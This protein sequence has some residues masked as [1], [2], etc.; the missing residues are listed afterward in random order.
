MDLQPEKITSI[1]KAAME[2]EKQAFDMEQA[3]KEL[4]FTHDPK[5]S[6]FANEDI[7]N[8]KLNTY[9]ELF[10]RPKK[11]ER[12]WIKENG[13]HSELQKKLRNQHVGA[14]GK[15]GD[16][17]SVYAIN[18]IRRL[19]ETGKPNG[20]ANERHQRRELLKD[21]AKL[22]ELNL[23]QK[24]RPRSANASGAASHAGTDFD[25][26]ATQYS[27]QSMAPSQRSR[28]ASAGAS[29]GSS[30]RAA[31]TRQRPATATADG[32]PRGGNHQVPYRY[33][34]FNIGTDRFPLDASSYLTVVPHEGR[35]AGAAAQRQQRRLTEQR[36]K[37]QEAA[38]RRLVDE[39]VTN[40]GLKALQRKH[41][42]KQ[43]IQL[44]ED[45][46]KE[47]KLEEQ[48]RAEAREKAH[49]EKKEAR[50]RKIRREDR[51]AM[52]E[53]H[54]RVAALEKAHAN[55]Q[56]EARERMVRVTK[57]EQEAI[58]AAERPQSAVVRFGENVSRSL[59]VLGLT[60][61]AAST[62]RLFE[63]W[64]HH[65]EIEEAKKGVRAPGEEPKDLDEMEPQLPPGSVDGDHSSMAGDRS[66]EA[67][68]AGTVSPTFKPEFPT[69]EEDPEAAM[70]RAR[71]KTKK[72]K[73]SVKQRLVNSALA[74]QSAADSMMA[75]RHF[76]DVEEFVTAATDGLFMVCLAALDQKI[77]KGANATPINVNDRNKMGT[78]AMYACMM[79]LLHKDEA[80][81]RRKEAKRQ[82]R[83]ERE[84]KRQHGMLSAEEANKMDEED[85]AAHAKRKRKGSGTSQLSSARSDLTPEPEEDAVGLTAEDMMMSNSNLPAATGGPVGA[86]Q[87]L[88]KKPI[89]PESLGSNYDRLLE[90]LVARGAN[91]GVRIRE[92]DSNRWTLLHHAA[93][94]GNTKRATWLVDK[95]NSAPADRDDG[96]PPLIDRTTSNGQTPLMLAV[97]HNHTSTVLHLLTLEANVDIQDEDGATAIHLAAA[98]GRTKLC[99]MLLLAGARK[100]CYDKNGKSPIDYATM[101]K[102]RATSDALRVFKPTAIPPR[103]YL[104]FSAM[105]VEAEKKAES[106]FQ[107]KLAAEEEEREAEAERKQDRSSI[108]RFLGR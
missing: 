78:T 2:R 30:A 96:Q 90:L 23:K 41:K 64:T 55:I 3:E 91:V 12:D 68:H 94:R 25:E 76:Y 45:I 71:R 57:E 104:H 34:D 47:D 92:P 82:R 99:K 37:L 42:T 61:T 28:P 5:L 49:A 97:Q 21:P 70:E 103:E 88:M 14:P 86:V 60:G 53:A 67:S 20:P 84:W 72:K 59:R 33:V 100:N 62:D 27:R 74:A 40:R 36:A 6:A 80:Q 106:E 50:Q 95:S 16:V 31:S 101:H 56:V 39:K 79:A 75:P 98:G 105:H 9:L 43:L 51:E 108:R 52:K 107:A 93:S 35:Q 46:K 22:A 32:R 24:K 54:A 58:E 87:W 10:P 102:H 19:K 11:L 13:L 15:G 65:Q 18:S 69:F 48:K 1:D 77:P 66:E 89:D 38:R 7:Y 63:S 44:M 8:Q 85:L 73:K 83:A 4:E 29:G 26:A 17:G 81:E